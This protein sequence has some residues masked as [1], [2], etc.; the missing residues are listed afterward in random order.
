MP[1]FESVGGPLVEP[2]A[3][4]VVGRVLFLGMGVG[5]RRHRERSL[6]GMQVVMV[7]LLLGMLTA[8]GTVAA[9]PASIVVHGVS[10]TRAAAIVAH[11]MDIRSRAFRHLLG[12]ADPQPWRVPCNVY[13]HPRAGDFAAAVGGPP[14]VARG[15]TSIEFAGTD[16]SL[17]RIDVMGDGADE[18]P[19]ALAHELVH[20]VLA[21]HFTSGP[22]PRWADEGIAVLF[23]STD[24][25]QGH[26][27]DF[28]R[29]A[30]AGLSW[31]VRD[32]FAL[33][34]YPAEQGRQRVFYGQSASLVRWLVDRRDGPT[35]IR[36]LDDCDALG[37]DEP[38]RRH[39]ALGSVT[40]LERAW[41]EVPSVDTVGLTERFR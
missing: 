27:H 5:S 2:T 36:F 16:I 24:K 35:F 8:T 3:M 1:A 6:S 13:V 38:L 9:E 31:R 18:I 30:R 17:R 20:V 15:A 34:N 39:Y 28:A 12:K 32:L 7:P 11:A 26:E 41:K 40:A 4:S 23:D 14:A 10:V 21:D 37:I 19:D 33:E 22:P 25:R 29:A